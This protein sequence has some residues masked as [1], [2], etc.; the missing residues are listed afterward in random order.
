MR[1]LTLALLA[2]ILLVPA[3]S[4]A[5]QSQVLVEGEPPLTASTVDDVAEFFGWLFETRFTPAQRRELERVLVS[6]W[7]T[8]DRKEIEA[9]Q[10]FGALNVKLLTVS[11]E[12]RA[13]ARAALL[14]DVQRAELRSEEHTS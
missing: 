11:K 8:G 3:G 9:A 13:E 10:Q 7:R 14:P 6:T 2:L 1:F 12:K 5:A 4:A